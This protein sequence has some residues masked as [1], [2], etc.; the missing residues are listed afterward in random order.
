MRLGKIQEVHG[1]GELVPHNG[2]R[3]KYTGD[4]RIKVAEELINSGLSKHDVSGKL[5][6][7]MISS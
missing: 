5:K 4:L 1:E 2:K 7:R 3:N 6:E